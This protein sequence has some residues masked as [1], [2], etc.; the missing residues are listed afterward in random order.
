MAATADC[1]FEWKRWELWQD[2]EIILLMTYQFS[3]KLWL[4]DSKVTKIH[5]KYSHN[6]LMHTCFTSPTNVYHWGRVTQIYVSKLTI[7]GS[8]NGLSPRRYQAIIWTNVGILFMGPLWTN[9]SEIQVNRNSYIIIQGNAFENVVRKLAAILSRL[10]CVNGCVHC[11]AARSA[12]Q[13]VRFYVDGIA[14]DPWRAS[15]WRKSKYDQRVETT[16]PELIIVE[17]VGRVKTTL[18]RRHMGVIATQITGNLAD[19]K[20]SVIWKAFLGHDVSMKLSPIE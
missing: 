5:Q 6:Y 3:L 13:L 17:K 9:I 8:D 16:C 1:S 4:S 15:A 19:I 14:P 18:Q 11:N 7:I 12:C 2:L 20:R 10:P